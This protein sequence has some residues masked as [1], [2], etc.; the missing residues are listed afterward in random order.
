MGNVK[1]YLVIVF[2]KSGKTT[3]FVVC[4]IPRQRN[5]D[6]LGN[7]ITLR[8]LCSPSNNWFIVVLASPQTNVKP[9]CIE[10][11]HAQRLKQASS[12]VS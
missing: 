10:D 6:Y 3:T 5:R 7:G 8:S 9:A 1:K 4:L 12:T 2:C 11:E